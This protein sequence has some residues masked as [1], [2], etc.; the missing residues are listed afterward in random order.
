MTTYTKQMQKI[1]DDYRLAKE[2]WPAS[3][4]TIAAWAFRTKRWEFPAF[5]AI[6]RCADDLAAAMR[7][8]YFID[9]KGR[10]VRVLYPVQKRSATGEQLTL[11]DDGRT[12]P[13]E[14]MHLSFQQTRRGIFWDCRQLKVNVDSYNDSHAG[15][16]PIQIVFDFTMD[17][18]ED[19][20]SRDDDA[21]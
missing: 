7:E 5:A 8:E 19:A 9:P 1:V 4:K 15:E 12:A 14:H 17:L 2:P 20:A 16:E 21:A 18:A 3:S 6:N 13:K 10:R 11:W